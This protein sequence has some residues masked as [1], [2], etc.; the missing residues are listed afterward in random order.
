MSVRLNA[1]AWTA[2]QV[3]QT[4]AP[5]YVASTGAARSVPR[6]RPSLR[7]RRRCRRRLCGR[8]QPTQKSNRLSAS[9][10]FGSSRSRPRLIDANP[11]RKCA[12]R[13][14]RSVGADSVACRYLSLE[15]YSRPAWAR[16][17]SIEHSHEALK[18]NHI[19][20][21][22]STAFA[23]TAKE[24]VASKKNGSGSGELRPKTLKEDATGF[25]QPF[26]RVLS[27]TSM[28]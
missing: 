15:E 8:V 2:W 14:V 18:K 9:A 5:T 4:F 20:T 25:E 6:H 26:M 11:F 16:S 28:P 24:L 13:H 10:S 19:R 27:R 22:A 12:Q 23:V 7:C 1:S 21:F 17:Q 3:T